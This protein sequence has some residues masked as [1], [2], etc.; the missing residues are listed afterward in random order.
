MRVANLFLFVAIGLGAY[1]TF[2]KGWE[3][4][5]YIKITTLLI[6]HY[7]ENLIYFIKQCEEETDVEEDSGSIQDL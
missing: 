4:I 1:C 3:Q 2:Y 6:I 5:D 7:G